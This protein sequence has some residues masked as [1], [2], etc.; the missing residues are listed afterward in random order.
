MFQDTKYPPHGSS[1]SN[2]ENSP[3]LQPLPNELI[4]RV[5]SRPLERYVRR[6]LVSGKVKNPD[7]V[8]KER[9]EGKQII[10]DNPLRDKL[11]KRQLHAPSRR[12]VISA[13]TRRELGL[14]SP[15]NFVPQSQLVLG[16]VISPMNL[17]INSGRPI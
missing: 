5:E 7:Q 3:L 16:I 8:L 4:P 2:K 15:A 13:K 10:L 17:C 12:A 11:A 6:L 1:N 14:F 9:V